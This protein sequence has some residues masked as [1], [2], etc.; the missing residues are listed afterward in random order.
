MVRYSYCTVRG[1]PVQNHTGSWRCVVCDLEPRRQCAASLPV[2]LC[3]SSTNPACGNHHL[4]PLATR[5]CSRRPNHVQVMI[6]QIFTPAAHA[7]ATREDASS[8][9]LR[10][11]QAA[12]IEATHIQTTSRRLLGRDNLDA[13]LLARL[14]VRRQAHVEALAIL[15][16]VFCAQGGMRGKGS[17]SA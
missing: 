15:R 4:S 5:R 1:A 10:C 9:S 11:A 12:E 17:V 13:T 16:R 2:V 14:A 3:R 8:R 7:A 6:S